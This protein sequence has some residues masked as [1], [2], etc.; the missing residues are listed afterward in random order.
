M[1]ENAKILICYNSPV[2]VFSV[3][4]GKRND[5][6][7]KANDLS[8]NNFVNELKKVEQSLSKYFTEVKSLA[9]DRNVQK[10]III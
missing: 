7:A 6:S 5:E 3:Y 9:V 2:S 8:E 1:K 4:N 10:V